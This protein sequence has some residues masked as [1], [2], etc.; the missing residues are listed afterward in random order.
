MTNTASDPAARQAADRDLEKLLEA[1]ADAWNRHDVE[2]LMS[3]MTE[4]G[5]FEAS[6]GTH[7]NG[8]R[9]QGQRA[10]RAAYEAVFAQYPDARWAD[11]Q[12][13]VTGTAVCPSGPSQAH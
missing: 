3:M 2:A 12:H 7:V 5:V 11:A 4:D 8:E 6:A 10:V 13:F 1:F 9:H